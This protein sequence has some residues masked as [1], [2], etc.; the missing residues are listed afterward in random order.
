MSAVPG[1]LDV[2]ENRGE[3]RSALDAPEWRFPAAQC[4]DGIPLGNGTFGA[5]V[6]GA[7]DALRLTVNR[8]DYWKHGG[9]W[10]WPAEATYAKLRGWLEAGDEATLR[11][12]FEGR[13]SPDGPRPDR[14]TRLPMGRV[15]LRLPNGAALREGWLDLDRGEAHLVAPVGPGLLQARAIVLRDRPIF[16]L[17]LDGDGARDATV[18][19]RP[20]DVPEVLTY[21]AAHGFPE[22][23]TFGDADSG[24]W[25]QVRPDEP[26]L[27]VGW[28]RR[29]A[30]RAA[31][32]FVAAVYGES[33]RAAVERARDEL[34]AAAARGY[35]SLAN[36]DA[37]WWREWWARAPR[38][39]LA[40]ETATFLYRF[41]LY[42]LA[43]LSVPGSPA[44]SLQG[45]WVEEYRF[46]PWSADFHFNVNVQEC[47]W[48][49]Y[50]GN[51][52]ECLDSL[53]SMLK[54]WEPLLR[55]NART[56]VGVEDGLLLPHAVDDRGT[57]MG[58]FWTGQTDHGST[59]WAGQLLWLRY[60]H[61]MDVDYLRDTVYPFLRGALRT[62]EPMLE[63]D[64]RRLSL[65]VGVSPEFGGSGGKAWG[66]N[67]SFQLA[68]IH[69]LCRALL[70]ASV[71]LGI[72]GDDQR[73]W[74][75]VA[76]RLP[77]GTI[78]DDELHLWQEMPLPESHRHHSHLAAFYPFGLLDP[79][80]DESHR[81]LVDR[82]LRR[83]TLLGTGQWTGWCVPWA[84]ILHARAGSG[85]GARH[86]LEA[87]RRFF[88]G[89]GH[90]STH[91]AVAR[92]FTVRTGNPSIMQIEA[93]LGASA[94]V[95][96][97]LAESNA[98]SGGV[99]RVFGGAP[100][101]HPAWRDVSFDGLLADGA[102]LL[103][104]RREDGRTAEVRVTSQA[105]GRLRLA[106][107]FG[108]GAVI[109]RQ[110]APGEEIVLR[111]S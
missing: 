96:E 24:G 16:A 103:S 34:A 67:A 19:P 100:T 10:T 94:A 46:P 73:R 15:D 30:G 77:L 42:K 53:E 8:A 11:R 104:A 17:R 49:A 91:D 69:F 56:Y 55:E 35:A 40:D 85:D 25:V 98:P 22:A 82:S 105:G 74:R 79:H 6:W 93:A 32:L 78:V 37:A 43:G 108:T 81:R 86:L 52:L 92:G 20:V 41:G 21:L 107:P 109:D 101:H 1:L 76:A 65:P 14:P 63:G 2:P 89:A 4:H 80:A 33:E 71:M 59:A 39:T 9:G 75:D 111:P 28:L 7:D 97:L 72:D 110:T 5:L 88:M 95:L 83:L 99:L 51:H 31:E 66:R 3:R 36:G 44:A 62:Y 38:V 45:P 68:C 29:P 106:D 64:E 58:G 23:R 47:Y 61:S 18:V 87:F 48:P 27:C 84:A 70:E 60:R 12:V 26:A 13:E 50:A 57:C 90:A 102:F 54:Q